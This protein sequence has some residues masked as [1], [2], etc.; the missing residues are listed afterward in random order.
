MSKHLKKLDNTAYNYVLKDVNKFIEEIKSL[1]EKIN[2]SLFKEFFELSSPAK[3]AKELINTKN[4]DE[5][6]K[7]DRRDKIQNIRF[8]RHNKRM[9]ENEKKGKIVYETLEIIKKFL[10]YNKEAQNFFHCASKV[11]KKIKTKD[12]RKYCREGKIKK[13]TRLLKLKKK[14]KT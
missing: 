14:K 5:N 2:L 10:D 4:Q 1:E 11:D 8:R 3:Y 6:K 12:C 7:K 13:K 9:S